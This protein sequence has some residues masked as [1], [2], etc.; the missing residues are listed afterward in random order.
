MIFIDNRV[1]A[2]YIVYMIKKYDSTGRE[3]NYLFS[4]GFDRYIESAEMYNY[5][6]SI[7]SGL[8]A[9]QMTYLC[10]KYKILKRTDGS[11]II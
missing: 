4:C 7:P 5:Y 11:T 10:D 9:A 8:I 2:I 1:N 6:K 3:H